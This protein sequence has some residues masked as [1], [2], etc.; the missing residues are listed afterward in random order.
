M[1]GEAL[2]RSGP[3]GQRGQASAGGLIGYEALTVATRQEASGLAG[4]VIH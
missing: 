4:E 2:D 1:E 3:P